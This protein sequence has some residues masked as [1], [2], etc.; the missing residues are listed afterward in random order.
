MM[1]TS[2]KAS[3][4]VATLALAPCAMAAPSVQV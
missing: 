2:L 1:R 4:L 3:C